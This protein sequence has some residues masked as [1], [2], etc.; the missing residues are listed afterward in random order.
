MRKNNAFCLLSLSIIICCVSCGPVVATAITA[1][2][3]NSWNW[4]T[5]WLDQPVCKPPCWQN[6][7]P[8]VTTR[9]EAVSILENTPGIVITYNK[10]NGLSWNFGTKTEGGNVVLSEDGIVSGVWLGST[11]KNLYLK[12]VVAAYSFPKYVNPFDCRDGMCDTVLVY[13]DLGV[14]LTVFVENKGVNND[15]PRL[16]ILPETI[17]YRVY[18]IEPGMENSQNYLGSQDNAP[19]MD[20]K[21]YGEYP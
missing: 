6:I 3:E 7:N 16:E 12:E 20:W 1:T 5:A 11:N 4:Q 17:V 15:T 14:L 19:I 18:F 2:P 21:G 8:G 10:K 13:L 9:D